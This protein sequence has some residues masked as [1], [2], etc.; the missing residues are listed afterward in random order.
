MAIN[1]SAL[2]VPLEAKIIL[3]QDVYDM[4]R[5]KEEEL[6]FYHSEL[7]KLKAKVSVLNR[8]IDLT[9]QIIT[10]IEHERIFEIKSSS[11]S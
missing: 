7:E 5:R 11:R 6:A 2:E 4:R 8:E 1:T 3:L 9:N 10:L